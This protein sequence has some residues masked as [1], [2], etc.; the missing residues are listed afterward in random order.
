M[1]LK[2]TDQITGREYNELR[3]CVGWRPI[4][5]EQAKRGELA[6]ATIS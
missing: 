4:T 3:K 6:N 5:D 2:Y 1:D